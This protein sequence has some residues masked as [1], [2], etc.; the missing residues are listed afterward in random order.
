M[1]ARV[2]KSFSE[3]SA[4]SWD[5][6]A[7]EDP[8]LRHAFLHALES[9]GSIGPGSG[10][11]ICAL[12]LEDEKSLAGACPLFAKSHSLGEYVFDWQVARHFSAQGM[13]YYPKLVA[14]VPFT[15]VAGSRLLARDGD[16]WKALLAALRKELARGF[17]SLNILFPS[18]AEAR[19]LAGSGFFLRQD[20]QFHWQNQGWQDFDEFLK[21]LSRDKRKK[22]LQ[23]RKKVRDQGISFK[24]VLG[25]QANPG[26]WDFFYRCY[27]ATYHQHGMRPY[28]NPAFF[29]RWAKAMGEAIVLVFANDKEAPL[30]SC[31]AVRGG[32]TLFGRYW[33]AARFVPGLHFETCYYQ[34]IEYCLQEGIELFEAGAQGEHKL[35]RGFLPRPTFSAHVM[36]DP[37]IHTRLER[38]FCI[39]STM[40]A[41]A[42]EDLDRRSPFREPF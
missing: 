31:L 7:G 5:V 26:K 27:S 38:A 9:S 25:S 33:G 11:D 4:A 1:R 14:A 16:A 6:L 30:A 36:S 8:F 23:E 2:L 42:L 24:T 12:V 39:E 32:K 15:P 40:Q 13:A 22:I 34:L 17:S 18:E 19:M 35:S 28:L 41:Q 20:H 21:S 10:W 29:R 3:V 37:E